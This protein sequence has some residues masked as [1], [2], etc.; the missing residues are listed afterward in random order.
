MRRA[1]ALPER[2]GDDDGAAERGAHQNSARRPLVRD[3]RAGHRRRER[4]KPD[5]HGA[6]R[7]GHVAQRP[8]PRTA[9]SRRRR[10]RR[11]ARA[12]AAAR[13]RATGARAGEHDGGQQRR[14]DRAAESDEHRVE[15]RD[16]DARRRQGQAEAR[17][18]DEARQQPAAIARGGSQ[19]AAVAGG[20]ASERLCGGAEGGS[21]ATVRARGR[22]EALASSAMQSRRVSRRFVER[23]RHCRHS[24]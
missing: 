15:R 6:V 21:F 3:Q 8:A 12:A 5:D 24:R 23:A 2:E 16:R 1:A 19:A 17:H 22:I 10:R 18:A 13:A 9:G 11:R 7:R 20:T 14:D 4:Q